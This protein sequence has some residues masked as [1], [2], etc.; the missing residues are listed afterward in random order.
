[1]VFRKPTIDDLLHRGPARIMNEVKQ[2]KAGVRWIHMR[3]NCM[4]WV[5]TLMERICEE[6]N[7][8]M[9]DNISNKPSSPIKINPLLR[10]D[11]WAHLFHGKATDQ[12]QSRFMG[13]T[14]TPFSVDMDDEQSDSANDSF[15]GPLDN[16][17]MYLPYLNWESVEAWH[18]R[19][20]LVRSVTEPQ[21]GNQDANVVNQADRELVQEFLIHDSPLHDRRTLHQAYYHDFVMTRALP[22]YN[23][24]MQRFTSRMNSKDGPKL[25][26]VD[27]LWLW[28]IKG[29]GS[30]GE[31]EEENPNPDLVITA[32]SGRF[33]GL[34]DSA[35]VYHGI[36]E[37]LERGI[38][39]P[40]RNTNDLVS[41][42]VEHCTG[43]FFQRQLESDKWF[44]EFFAAAIGSIREEQKSAFSEFRQTSNQLEDLQACQASLIELSRKLEDPAFS[45]SIETSLF[46]QIKDII[47][48]LDCVDY[49][50]NRQEEV[51]RALTRTQKTQKSRSLRTVSDI[52]TERRKTWHGI[53][54]TARV[55]YNEIQAQ[56]DLKQKQSS[57]AEARTSRYQVEDSARHGRIMLLF[58][59]VTIVFLPMSFLAT[60]FGMNIKGGEDNSGQLQ[61][62]FIALV[63]FPVSIIIAG[64][65]LAF[66]FSQRL[67]DWLAGLVE[68]GIDKTL[69][70]LGIHG[71]PG[72]QTMRS[73]PRRDLGRPPRWDVRMRRLTQTGLDETEPPRRGDQPI[74]LV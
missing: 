55:A 17:V 21:P 5:E 23:Q 9:A 67:R 29:K 11:L 62:S 48:E 43:V 31:G 47:D 69:D 38:E 52:V 70:I 34:P 30:T 53:S 12:I 8:H 72:G 73:N 33:N 60:W 49:I 50:L 71:S 13:P 58:T 6:R 41:V 32:F 20:G 2:H 16:L 39:P 68:R 15:H 19:Q 27:Q 14:C 51:V 66:A 10:K 61:L 1:M 4:S 18:E 35:D 54:L 65:A 26:V 25:L 37:H 36:I 3:S 22:D 28:I 57:L 59:V 7:I 24:V 42:I 44:L 74:E 63:I 46:S 40:L 64:V 56:M 45:I